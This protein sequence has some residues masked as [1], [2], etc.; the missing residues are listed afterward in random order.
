[1]NTYNFTLILSESSQQID[2]LEDLLFEAGCDDATL[3][4]SNGITYLEFDRDGDQFITVLNS[5]IKQVESINDISVIKHIT[6][7]DLVTK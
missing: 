2:N 7:E 1:M 3:S 4:F 5:A 6:Q